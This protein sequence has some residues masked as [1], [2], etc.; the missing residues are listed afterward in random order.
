MENTNKD[1]SI[2][3]IEGTS[4]EDSEQLKTFEGDILDALLESAAYATGEE[5]YNIRVI[6]NKKIMFQFQIRPLSVIEMLVSKCRRKPIV[7]VIGVSSFI[8]LRFLK[9]VKEFGITP[10]CGASLMWQ[11]G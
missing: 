8:W 11:V 5:T 6:R 7:C 4:E 2:E 10:R 1:M 3:E 9:I